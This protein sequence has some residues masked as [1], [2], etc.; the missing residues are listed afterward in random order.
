MGACF[1]PARCATK[2]DRI[3]AQ[4]HANNF[5]VPYCDQHPSNSLFKE[6]ADYP[7]KKLLKKSL[8]SS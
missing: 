3:G 7:K 4:R 1:V 5:R 6:R 2:A 8:I